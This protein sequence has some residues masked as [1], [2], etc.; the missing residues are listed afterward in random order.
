MNDNHS[1]S[2]TFGFCLFVIAVFVALIFIAMV[3]VGV[4][5]AR[6]HDL[7]AD[8]SP[9]PAWVKAACCGPN[10]VHHLVPSQVHALRDGWHVDGYNSAVPY[11][12][13]LPSEDG[14]Y[15]G[16]WADYPHGGQSRMYCFFTPS[17]GS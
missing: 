11:G 13:E 15:W 8:G 14:D 12:T 6:A 3:S 5:V 1:D 4:P 7:W 16:F 17:Q 10:D 9:V 2:D